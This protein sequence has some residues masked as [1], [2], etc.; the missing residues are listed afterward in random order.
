M[1]GLVPLCFLCGCCFLTARG[2]TFTNESPAGIKVIWAVPANVWPVEKIWS[3]KVIPQEFSEAVISN[4]LTI[5]SFTMKDRKPAPKGW[6][7]NGYKTLLFRNADETKYLMIC[8]ALGCIE[9]YD[10]NAEA[11]A[12]SAI[13]DVP[14]PVV[15]VPDLGEATRL[16][17]KYARLLGIEISQFARKP[18]TCDFDLHWDITTRRW[19]DQKTKN[20]IDEIQGFGIDFTRCIDGIEMSGFGDVYVSFGNNAKL[21]ELNVSWRNLKPYQ[22]L[23]KFITPEEIVE[24][25]QNGRARLPRL[26]GWPLDQIKSL[27][28]TNAAPRYARK[29]G[30]EA[31]DFVYPALQLDAIMDNGKTNRHTWFQMGILPPKKQT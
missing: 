4:A 29:P 15:G 25:I 12:T 26:A 11:K 19:M 20:E 13:K 31:M 2:G 7:P 21:G 28:I 24:S 8:P 1:R 23:A 22:L 18:G 30:D 16:G 5:A 10:G 27:T 14:E 6:M 3:Y 9:Y 17:L